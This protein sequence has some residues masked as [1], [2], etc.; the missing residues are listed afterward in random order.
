MIFIVIIS[1]CCMCFHAI[2]SDSTAEGVGQELRE[3]TAWEVLKNHE[4][5]MYL[6]KINYVTKW[7]LFT[8]QRRIMIICSCDVI[9]MVNITFT[10]VII[11]KYDSTSHVGMVPKKHGG[12]N[13]CITHYTTIRWR[14]KLSY[15][16]SLHVQVHLHSHINTDAQH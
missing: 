4:N 15:V 1:Y 14:V 7:N 16:A 12:S 13:G 2:V 3:E 10:K 8:N 9:L 6:V 11:R 5:Y